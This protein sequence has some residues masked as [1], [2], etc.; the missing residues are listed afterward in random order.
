MAI[1]GSHEAM[2]FGQ[3]AQLPAQTVSGAR[4]AYGSICQK[5]PSRINTRGNAYQMWTV[6]GYDMVQLRVC[7]V[8]RAVAHAWRPQK[9]DAVV[10]LGWQT[11]RDEGVVVVTEWRRLGIYHPVK[12]GMEVLAAAASSSAFASPAPPSCSTG[13]AGGGPQAASV[14]LCRAS[15]A[16]DCAGC[17][18]S[19]GVCIC[20]SVHLTI[21]SMHWLDEVQMQCSLAIEGRS[22]GST[23]IPIRFV[24]WCTVHLEAEGGGTIWLSEGRID[25]SEPS[26]IA[27][28]QD[29]TAGST[30]VF[31][32]CCCCLEVVSCHQS[33]DASG[34]KRKPQ[35]ICRQHPFTGTSSQ[36]VRRRGP[37]PF[38]GFK[39]GVVDSRQQRLT[40]LHNVHCHYLDDRTLAVP[41]RVGA[42]RGGDIGQHVQAHASIC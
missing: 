14:E 28:V 36:E 20:S 40:R 26:G 21:R 23:T 41:S 8:G 11:G 29:L 2:A 6:E 10:L 13:L 16:A 12:S 33:S 7:L 37:A 17:W 31:S 9:G 38:S 39:A 42:R 34:R 5:S 35:H 18:C 32:M 15:S 25:F 27:S 24:G 30:C 1:G 19:D 4:V 22:M 3:I